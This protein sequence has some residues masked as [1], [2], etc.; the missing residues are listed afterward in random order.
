MRRASLKILPIL[1]VLAGLAAPAAADGGATLDPALRAAI[2]GAARDALS[3]TGA[4]SAAVAVVKDGRIAYVQAYGS[5]RLSPAVPADPKM[6]YSIGSVSKQ[7]TATAILMLAEEGKLSL[8]DPVSRFVPGLTRGDEVTIRQLLSHTSGYQDYWPQDYVPPFMLQPTTAQAILDHW[9]KQPLDFE[10]GTQYQYSN[11][12]YVIAGVI[13][14]RASGM[15]LLPFL[16]A[17]IFQPLAMGS[18]ANIDQERLGDT[19][20]TGYIRYALGPLRP[21]PKEGKGWLFAAG[22]LAMTAEDLARW[23]VGM[24]QQKLLK[25]ASYR[26]MQTEVLLKNGLGISYGL[27][28]DVV[29]TGGRRTLEHGG[30]VSGFT[31]ENVVFPDD[32]A[33]ITVLVNQDAIGTGGVI[34]HKIADL[35]FAGDGASAAAARARRIFEGL[36][37]GSLDRTLFTSNANSY[38]SDQVVQDFASGLAPL[39]APKE[40]TARRGSER[41]GMTFRLFD[42]RFAGRT[43]SIWERDMP[44]G[45]IEQFQV[46]PAE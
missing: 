30:E 12:G 14:E 26:Q 1:A 41:G 6:R 39:G 15:P 10:P 9:A 21:A 45:K 3:A 22:E 4:P 7:F 33:A 31:A 42:V 8:D 17:R 44:D 24:L 46:M 16:S 25:P 32:N 2:D 5:A 35:L 19:D 37:H 28:I 11:T 38:F 13:V 27:G 20:P 43:L 40:V 18:V 29:K 34:A 36:Q 23:N